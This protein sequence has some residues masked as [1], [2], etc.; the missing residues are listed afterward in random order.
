[1]YEKHEERVVLNKIHER[2]ENICFYF[3][4]I[5]GHLKEKA[6]KSI[7][8]LKRDA[9]RIKQRLDI[10]YQCEDCSSFIYC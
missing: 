6:I 9:L 1:M 5:D 8:N 3:S 4:D 7:G 10:L 2:K